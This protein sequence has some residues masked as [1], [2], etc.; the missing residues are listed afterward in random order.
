MADI[1]E[2]LEDA[3]EAEGDAAAALRS[4]CLSLFEVGRER[5]IGE[6]R[7]YLSFCESELAPRSW[8]IMA[9]RVAAEAADEALFLRRNWRDSGELLRMEPPPRLSD[10]AAEE[11]EEVDSSAVE[12]MVE[13][14]TLL[15]LAIS[16]REGNGEKL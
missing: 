15:S 16:G 12:A 10:S 13:S 8:W 4:C 2:E 11:E 14:G 3:D 7:P 6:S 5:T 9:G 1:R